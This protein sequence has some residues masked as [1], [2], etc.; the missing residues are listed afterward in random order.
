LVAPPGQVPGGTVGV[1]AAVTGF[2]DLQHPAG[3]FG[4]G[5]R[6]QPPDRVGVLSQRPAL[7]V[8]GHP[9]AVA[10]G[11]GLHREHDGHLA[12]L[13][14]LD[15]RLDERLELPFAVAAEVQIRLVNH[16]HPE[17]GVAPEE[18][19]E[20]FEH[21]VAA[22][23]DLGI[24]QIPP[25]LAGERQG[26]FEQSSEQPLAGP[27]DPVDIPPGGRDA[28]NHLAGEVVPAI[29]HQ[30]I[31]RG[32]RL[33]RAAA[34]ERSAGGDPGDPVG[35][36]GRLAGPGLPHHHNHIP[37]PDLVGPDPALV[38]MMDGA[39]L[40]HTVAAQAI[41]I[42]GNLVGI[43]PVPGREPLAGHLGLLLVQ[44]RMFGPG[45]RS[46]DSSFGR[47]VIRH[48]RNSP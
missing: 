14:G 22:Q 39:E 27:V 17:T 46:Q 5:R 13:G 26:E 19:V 3:D 25:A 33:F 15:Q 29:E 1:A 32:S 10:E 6:G 44:R 11:V 24:A 38:F 41:G 2:D 20:R 12:L 9:L 43:V 48:D 28:G 34:G 7:Q 23:M 36:E 8:F 35:H 18:P 16:H 47:R 4:I 45:S 31:P 37:R 30:H 42:E 40:V 21:L